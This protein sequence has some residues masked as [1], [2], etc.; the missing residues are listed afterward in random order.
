MIIGVYCITNKINN[1]KYV[2]QS[3]NVPMRLRQHKNKL[4]SGKHENEYLQA[5]W[6][7][8]GANNFHFGILEL[9]PV[10]NKTALDLVEQKYIYALNT[11]NE[12]YGYNMKSGG[13]VCYMSDAVKAKISRANKGQIPYS[14]GKPMSD[15][16]KAKIS[17]ANKGRKVSPETLAKLKGKPSHNKGKPMSEEQKAK[18]AIANT[19]KS[20]SPETRAKISKFN[21]GRPWS[22]ARRKAHERR[23]ENA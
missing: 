11:M 13:A 17:K 15:E 1:K 9:Y 6:Q 10:L 5:S 16:Q 2:G 23:R 21:K 14:K 18:I 19:G 22:D 4:N 12:E 8:Y 7:K 3:I 20:V